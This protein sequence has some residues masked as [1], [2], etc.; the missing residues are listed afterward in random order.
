MLKEETKNL[1][2]TVDLN[3]NTVEWISYKQF[4]EATQNEID[5]LFAKYKIYIFP[6]EDDKIFIK[7]RV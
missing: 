5:E 6:T 7:E 1:L 2:L 3:P 4:V